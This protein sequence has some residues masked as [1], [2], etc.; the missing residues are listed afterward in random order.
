MWIGL[1]LTLFVGTSAFAETVELKTGVTLTAPGSSRLQFAT[2]VENVRTSA[3]DIPTAD[4]HDH[5]ALEDAVVANVRARIPADTNAKSFLILR[6]S[7]LTTLKE[8]EI[9]KAAAAPNAVPS[10]PAPSTA[11]QTPQSA[12]APL[13][14]NQQ[15]LIPVA[16]ASDCKAAADVWERANL[17][18]WNQGKNTVLVVFNRDAHECYRTTQNAATGDVIFI[19]IAAHVDDTFQAKADLSVCSREPVAPNI[20]ISGKPSDVTKLQ[21]GTTGIQYELRILENRRCWDKDITVTVS[22]TGGVVAAPGNTGTRPLSFFERFRGTLQL[23]VLYTRLHDTDFGLVTTNGQQTIYNKE[24]AKK[25]PE[26]VA[27]VLVYGLPHYF[28]SDGWKGGYHGRDILNDNGWADRLGL[29]LIAGIKNPSDRFGVGLSFE[30]AYGINVFWTKEWFRQNQL[31]GLKEGA[32]F[33]GGVADITTKR[34][35]QQ[36]NS[37]GLSFDIRYITAL[38]KQQ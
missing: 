6:N 23:G 38:F 35:W 16:T 29:S 34:E 12:P 20:Y 14:A 26:Y 24:A 15:P 10:P 31:V 4:F 18:D 27:S 36:D 33:T 17:K 1:P 9:A 37:F 25:G 21:A 7:Q 3:V 11:S 13:T 5:L 19:G 28:T 32:P 8:F 22:V 30:L 2:Q